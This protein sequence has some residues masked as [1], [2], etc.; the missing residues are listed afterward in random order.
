MTF[1]NNAKECDKTNIMQ[2]IS[3]VNSQ[4][5]H[6]DQTNQQPNFAYV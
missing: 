6:I 1:S 4:T 2:W 5:G 3:E